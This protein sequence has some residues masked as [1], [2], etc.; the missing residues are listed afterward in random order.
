[1]PHVKATELSQMKSVLHEAKQKPSTK[2]HRYSII[3]IQSHN[4]QGIQMLFPLLYHVF[5]SNCDLIT[6]FERQ[7]G[8]Q[9]LSGDAAKLIIYKCCPPVFEIRMTRPVSIN[10]TV[11]CVK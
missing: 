8:A 3:N 2:L 5:G 11:G 10:L 1:M 6:L 7:R 9:P 4:L